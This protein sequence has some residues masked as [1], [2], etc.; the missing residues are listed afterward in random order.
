[1]RWAG[2]SRWVWRRAMRDA[3]RATRAGSCVL[4]YRSCWRVRSGRRQRSATETN[5]HTIAA[6]RRGARTG[7]PA[8]NATTLSG[9]V[10]ARG[11]AQC[12]WR[13]PSFP[14]PARRRHAARWC[15]VAVT[16]ARAAARSH[17]HAPPPI[18][19]RQVGGG[20]G[21]RSIARVPLRHGQR[22]RTTRAHARPQPPSFSVA[23]CATS[24]E[25]CSES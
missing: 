18:Q 12:E 1:M 9:D 4:L 25:P 17:T 20:C 24:L 15:G 14:Q 13:A 22:T 10:R 16:C 8:P 23:A 11:A 21:P 2:E 19:G 3:R 5:G 7:C 6:T